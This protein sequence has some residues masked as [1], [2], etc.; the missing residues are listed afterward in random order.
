MPKN[1]DFKNKTLEEIEKE[2]L[3]KMALTASQRQSAGITL[4]PTNIIAVMIFIIQIVIGATMWS[5]KD[6][7]ERYDGYEARI[8]KAEDTL[9]RYEDIDTKLDNLAAQFAQFSAQPRFTEQD[10]NSKLADKLEPMKSQLDRI[11]NSLQ[12]K[13]ARI[14]EESDETHRRLRELETEFEI[15]KRMQKE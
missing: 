6:K 11:E 10:F 5:I 7:I 1:E 4:T 3:Y 2:H 15:L 9:I 14:E 8:E 12:A 13:Q